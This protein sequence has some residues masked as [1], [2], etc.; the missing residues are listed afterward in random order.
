MW[1]YI[2]VCI[3]IHEY[4]YIGDSYYSPSVTSRKGVS[5]RNIL[6]ICIFIHVYL[7]TCKNRYI[8][9]YICI[10]IHECEYIG[11]S[12]Y[13]PSVTSRKG[14]VS[15]RNSTS[16]SVRGFNRIDE[17]DDDSMSETSDDRFVYYFMCLHR[18]ILYLYTSTT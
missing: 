14:A 2:Y 16:G 13:S 11:D 4:E 15:S 5:S 8:Y 3:C 9:I 17:S 1:K 12:Y 10:C 6:H 18:S 7:R